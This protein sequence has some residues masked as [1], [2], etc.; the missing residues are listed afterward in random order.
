MGVDE[1]KAVRRLIQKK[2]G[3][4]MPSLRA[5]VLSAITILGCTSAYAQWSPD[6]PI[7][8]VVP[9]AAGGGADLVARLIGN[10]FQEKLGQTAY[11]ENRTGAGG[12]IGAQ[13]VSTADPDGQTLL[14]TAQ[15]PLAVNK[16][17]YTKL[18]YDPDALTSVSLVVVANS[19]LLSNP[20]VPAKSLADL[21]KIAREKPGGLNYASQGVGTQAHL[22]AELF[23]SVAK[24]KLTHVPYGGS[25]P[26]LT[27][28]VNGVVD[29][30]FGE[31]APSGPYITSGSLNAIAIS[32]AER[33]PS[34]PGVPTMAETFPG[35]VVT[36][37]WALVGPPRMST[38]VTNRLSKAVTDIV[39][40]PEI[41]ERLQGLGMIP[42]GSTPAELDDF[43]KKESD[44]WSSVVKSTGIVLN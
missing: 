2:R 22:T 17:L 40:D 34:L 14:F 27:D 13:V 37:W 30:M 12:N 28:L 18:S 42:T 25:G 5:A 11:V 3:N 6:R 15:G 33:S 38:T 36:S 8:I 31:L 44:R 21:L 35:F 29:I 26:A 4:A 7:R 24:V 39:R 10:K 16:A 32:G 19:V 1:S 23:S 9:Y 20:K 43:R 41:A